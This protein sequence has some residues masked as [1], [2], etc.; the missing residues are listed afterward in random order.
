MKHQSDI[1]FIS[2]LSY[3]WNQCMSPIRLVR[4]LLVVLIIQYPQAADGQMTYDPSLEVTALV[5]VIGYEPT[6]H[7]IPS[8]DVTLKVD[9]VYTGTL[10][11]SVLR[12][13][14]LNDK[15]LVEKIFG[16]RATQ[17]AILA[18]DLPFVLKYTYYQ[19]E[20]MPEAT[21]QL[22]WTATS[23][24]RASLEKL[25]SLLIPFVENNEDTPLVMSSPINLMKN[26]G[27]G[28]LFFTDDE[29][30][31]VYLET[32]PGSAEWVLAVPDEGYTHS[33]KMSAELLETEKEGRIFYE[34]GEQAKI[35]HRQ[36]PASDYWFMAT[37]VEK[38]LKKDEDK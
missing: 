2:S 18:Q 23:E 33:R 29:I 20:M 15:Y 28:R 1:H 14:G 37:A 35:A 16:Q 24:R 38:P 21:Y 5:R 34:E 17:A 31:L 30:N 12:F 36:N 6:P 26:E 8:G 22:I 9:E 27:F 3:I 7:H 4:T 10:R 11:D 19:E 13:S 25:E 32:Y